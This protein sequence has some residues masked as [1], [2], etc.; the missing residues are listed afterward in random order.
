MERK[1]VECPALDRVA[2]AVEHG[3]A[4]A[5]RWSEERGDDDPQ[6]QSFRRVLAGVARELHAAME[7]AHRP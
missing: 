6:V 2:G 4:V 1:R 3:Y 7:I 5:E